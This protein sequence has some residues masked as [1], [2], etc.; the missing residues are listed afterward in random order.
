MTD[1][2]NR[3]TFIGFGY[4]GVAHYRAAMPA[5]A[6]GEGLFIRDDRTLAVKKVVGE[7]SAPV[8]VY[9]NP[10]LDFQLAECAEILQNGGRLIVDC[11]DDLRACMDNPHLL[12]PE[13]FTEERV[14]AWES[15]LKAATLV[16]TSTEHIA[17]SLRKRLGVECMVCPNAIDLDRFNI[18]KHP[19]AKTAT[20]IGWSGGAGHLD[21]I[22]RV[23]PALEKVLAERKDIV[24]AMIGEPAPG[25]GVEKLLPNAAASKQAFDFGFGGLYEYPQVLCQFHIGLA[26]AVDNEFYRGKSD[27]R[28]LEYAASYVYPIAQQP[29]YEIPVGGGIELRAEA[30]AIDWQEAIMQAIADPKGRYQTGLRARKHVAAKR[31]IANTRDAWKAAIDRAL[32][33]A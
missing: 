2:K 31:T 27:I 22:E 9:N 23:V 3:A 28:F 5:S 30:E 32:E 4:A 14:A 17:D 8:I 7:T 21:A 6:L 16:T 10:Y 1:I 18:Q 33:E 25:V 26:P 13:R 19:R 24:F 15:C 29:T 11:D 20:V 12:S